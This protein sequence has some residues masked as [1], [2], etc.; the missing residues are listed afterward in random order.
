MDGGNAPGIAAE[1][2]RTRRMGPCNRRPMSSALAIV[3]V[4]RQDLALA[5]MVGRTDHALAFHA[6]DDAGGAVVADLQ[7]ALDEA[8]AAFA[9]ARHQRD[10]L[11]IELVAL[12]VLALARQAE[13]ALFR[14]GIVGHRFDV[15]RHAL[16][17]QVPHD[18]LDLVSLTNGPCTRAILPPPAM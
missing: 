6:L 8:R 1:A 13:P 3:D 11:V 17:T 15:G 9:L 5:D 16:R 12:A 14:I 18:F 4:T 10:R 7:V 2:S